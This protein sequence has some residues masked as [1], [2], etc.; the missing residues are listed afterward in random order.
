MKKIILVIS[1]LWIFGLANSQDMA[2]VSDNG[3]KSLNKA[4]ITLES[5]SWDFGA[6][7]QNVPVSHVFVIKN[8]GNVPLIINR[9]STTCG[10]TA[11]DYP[12]EAILPNTSANITITYNA[13]GKGAFDKSAT[14]YSNASDDVLVLKVKGTVD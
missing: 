12:K 4:C 1:A 10:C 14:V 2:S 9:V 3:S 13:S 5:D 11:S 7:R 8:T 6:I